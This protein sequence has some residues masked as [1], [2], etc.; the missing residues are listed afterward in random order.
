MIETKVPMD[1]RTYKAK[2]IGPFTTRQLICVS[3]AV[4][5]DALLFFGVIH[6]LGLPIRLAVFGLV[7][8]DFPIIAFIAEPMGMPMEKYLKNVLWKNLITPTKRKAKSSIPEPKAAT[9]TSKEQKQS[10]NK[11]AKLIKT[12]PEYKAYK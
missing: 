9:Y 7:F 3:A 8:V 11:M 10:K 4:C 5:L 6:P 1:V 12:H 2:L